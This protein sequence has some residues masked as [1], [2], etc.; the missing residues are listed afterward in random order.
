VEGEGGEGGREQRLGGH[1]LE[2]LQLGLLESLG[3]GP[4][5]LEPDLDLCLRQA[6]GP[7]ELGPLGDGQVLF[8]SEPPLQGQQLGRGE[9][10]PRFSVVL[11][12][13]QGTRRGAGDPWK[14]IK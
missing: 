12:F 11:V 1:E 3:L 8:L 14:L 10:G 4:A 9:G 7:G 5:V 2:L 13:S 6:E